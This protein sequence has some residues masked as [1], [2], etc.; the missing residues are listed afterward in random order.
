M[1]GGR[2]P[3]GNR[4]WIP[5]SGHPDSHWRLLAA[6]TDGGCSTLQLRLDSEPGQHHAK[7]GQQPPTREDLQVEPHPF[8]S[9]T[10][11]RQVADS[12]MEG[13]PYCP[14][15]SMRTHGTH[16]AS[17]PY[18]SDTHEHP[19]RRRVDCGTQPTPAAARDQVSSLCCHCVP[20]AQAT[21]AKKP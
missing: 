20:I 10:E 5:R 1:R 9:G 16:E 6:A 7:P 14:Q 3:R 17:G 4:L 12:G 15:S 8:C 19:C 13:N 21:V 2:D 18:N 11:P